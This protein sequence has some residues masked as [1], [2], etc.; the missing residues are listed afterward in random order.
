M[1]LSEPAQH[2]SEG[3][4][5]ANR[6]VGVLGGLAAKTGSGLIPIGNS[7]L[8]LTVLNFPHT[9]EAGFDF[10]PLDDFCQ[11]HDVKGWVNHF[12]ISG[13][14]PHLAVILE[15]Q[16]IISSGVRATQKHSRQDHRSSLAAKS[17]PFFDRLRDW[18]SLRARQDG[19]PVYV[20]FTNK[21]LAS[22]AENGPQTK[23]DLLAIE[24]IGKA[25]AEKYAEDVFAVLASMSETKTDERKEIPDAGS[26]E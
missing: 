25:K 16:I 11:T 6:P 7:K 22:I 18:R 20:V 3:G 13:G 1:A 12:Y 5:P 4:G 24:G 26:S 19:V 15:Y 2:T 14:Q 9:D 8:E 10:G 21:E 17:R 23:T